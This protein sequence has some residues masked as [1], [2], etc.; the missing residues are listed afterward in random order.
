M[1]RAEADLGQLQAKLV[2]AE[3]DWHRARKLG[4]GDALSQSDYDAAL[5]ASEVARANVAVGKAAIARP[6]VRWSG[7]GHAA[8]SPAEPGLLHHQITGPRGYHRPAVNIGQTVVAS[9]NAPSLFL[10]A[11]D[12]RRLQVWVAVNEA[13]VGSIHPGSR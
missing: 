10:I 6:P 4:P 7:R 9:F 5:S 13:D 1:A 11:K 12:L 8:T 2:Q 3:R